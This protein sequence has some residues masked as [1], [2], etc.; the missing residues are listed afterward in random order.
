MPVADPGP[1]FL[2][3]SRNVG[4]SPGLYGPVSPVLAA[5]NCISARLI[6]RL[7]GG[8][9][10]IEICFSNLAHL[11]RGAAETELLFTGSG[12]DNARAGEHRVANSAEK[13]EIFTRTLRRSGLA[14]RSAR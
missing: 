2:M 13:I 6:Q 1:L 12:A 9:V 3:V 4:V 5:L 10:C 14:H 8:N 7:A 11:H